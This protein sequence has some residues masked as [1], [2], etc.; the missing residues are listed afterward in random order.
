V[1]DAD[2]LESLALLT[3]QLLISLIA[4]IGVD[5]QDVVSA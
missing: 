1:K 4:D 3:R 2:H 5:Y